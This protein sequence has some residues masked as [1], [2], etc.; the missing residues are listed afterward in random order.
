MRSARFL[1]AAALLVALL[2]PCRPVIAADPPCLTARIIV[3]WGAGS[4]TDL[5]FRA[6][7][8]AANRAGAKPRLEVVNLSGSDGVRGSQ[9]ALKARP[10]GCTLLAVHQSLMTSYIAGEASFNWSDFAP[11]ARLTRTPAVI[12]ARVDAGFATLPEM[13]RAAREPAGVTAGATRGLGSH[14]LFLMLQERTGTTFKPVFLDGT[15]ERL[16]ALLAGS[17][18]V[19]ELNIASVRRLL[20]ERAI[21]ALAVTGASRA[22]ALPDVPTL[23]E[24]GV[25]LV[26]TIDRGVML[27]KKAAP[28]LVDRYAALF[29]KALRDPRVAALLDE[30]GTAAAFL[31]PKPYAGYW[32]DGF[33]QWRGLAKAAGIYRQ[34]D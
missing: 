33:A 2:L 1:P 7:A 22:A 11:V 10:D 3:P 26:F 24:Q 31:A 12:A 23:T 19:A 15:R 18:D 14:F 4:G 28:E 17:V 32:Q 16:T 5:L 20:G 6:L 9:E 29:D 34:A 8:E 13:L 25:D 30:H 21:K 27:P